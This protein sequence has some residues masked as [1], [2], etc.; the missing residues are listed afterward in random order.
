M[1]ARQ[2]DATNGDHLGSLMTADADALFL[3][4]DPDPKGVKESTD[5]IQDVSSAGRI[6]CSKE[7]SFA[8]A[9]G[10]DLGAKS[11]SDG[12]DGSRITPKYKLLTGLRWCQFSSTLIQL[13]DMDTL[14][15]P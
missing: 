15:L 6:T 11:M 14:S 7:D 9:S 12:D 1:L 4:L 2:S 8:H 5:E 10:C 3:S 13:V